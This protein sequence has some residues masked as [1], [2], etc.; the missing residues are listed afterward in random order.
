VGFPEQVVG[1]ALLNSACQSGNP[2][3]KT[4]ESEESILQEVV[5]K[6]LKKFYSV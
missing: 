6:P 5:L 1:L 4:N 2:N 3:E